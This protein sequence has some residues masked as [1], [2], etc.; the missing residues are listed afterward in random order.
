[1]NKTTFVKD[2][3]CCCFEDD[4]SKDTSFSCTKYLKKFQY[5]GNLEDLDSLNRSI[6]K[7]L[8]LQI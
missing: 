6:E 4:E 8:Q 1:M 7:E 3:E 5:R 2:R